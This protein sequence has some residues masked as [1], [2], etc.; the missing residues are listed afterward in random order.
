MMTIGSM[1][2]AENNREARRPSMNMQGD[3][4]SKN[5][6]KQIANAQKQMQ[7]LSSNEDMSLEEKMKKRQAIQQEIAS[8][9]QQLR[10][11]Q[12]EKRK[13]QQSKSADDVFG[14][15]SRNAKAA[16]SKGRKGSGSGLSQAS[17]QAMISADSSM[18]QV[19]VQGSVA[20]QMEGRARVLEG[21]IKQDGARGG[22]VEKK[23]AELA[24]IQQQAQAATSSQMSALANA[25][26]A[27]EEAAAA[28]SNE[29][30]TAGESG[31]AG[32]S[33]DTLGNADSKPSVQT[34]GTAVAADV[35]PDI[36]Q[37]VGYTPIDIRL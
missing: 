22:N 33:K 28:E 11:H 3:S 1:T 20:T 2:G 29:K 6:Q 19:Q 35:A 14:G 21:E 15:S 10:Q 30:E 17:M 18:K 31:E 12:M 8:L 7:E 5:I 24:D 13:E 26:Q 9:N 4:F 16:K 34:E 23:E 37:P 36:P 27:M 25:N 32:K